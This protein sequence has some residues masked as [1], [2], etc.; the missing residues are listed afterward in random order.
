M[1]HWRAGLLRLGMADVRRLIC[2]ALVVAAAVKAVDVVWRAEPAVLSIAWLLAALAVARFGGRGAVAVAAVAF[3]STAVHV[4][5]G[6]T[7]LIGWVALTVATVTDGADVVRVLRALTMAVYGFA[8]LH[9]LTGGF[10]TGQ[11][12]AD[13]TWWES[14]PVEL[15]AVG[16]V[17]TQAWLV[18]AL[19]RRS[20]F[21]APVAVG[22]H[23][24]IVAL[25]STTG[26]QLLRL[27]MFN[28]LTALLV[29]VVL[30]GRP[31]LHQRLA[32]F[33]SVVSE[34]ATGAV[35]GVDGVCPL[36]SD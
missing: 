19:W 36:P 26:P 23:I 17:V 13:R 2:R 6:H 8:V 14:A 31:N 1:G 3:F 21:A 32:P 24:G 28:G 30:S 25:M 35:G 33:G 34:D 22:L 9:K 10:L 15:L 5:A 7:T 29:V 4:P 12:I 18:W 16:A 27:T 11:A 20:I